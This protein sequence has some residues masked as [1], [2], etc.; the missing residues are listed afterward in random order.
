METYMDYQTICR[1]NCV[2]PAEA[3][4]HGV[5]SA[6]KEWRTPSLVIGTRWEMKNI[7]GSFNLQWSVIKGNFSIQ[8][9]HEN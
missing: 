3:E 6:V 9:N 7:P 8:Q 1:W 2:E 5:K 4:M